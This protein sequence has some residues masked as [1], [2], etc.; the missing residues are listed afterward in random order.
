MKKFSGL[1]TVLLL[2]CV[3]ASVSSAE[4]ASPMYIGI[5]DIN[6]TLTIQSGQATCKG[7]V[8]LNS[9]SYGAD[10]TVTLQKQNG[11]SWVYVNSW[12]DSGSI[13]VSA[14]G[15][16]SVASGYIY[17]VRASATV[18]DS[19]GNVVERG[20]AYSAQKTY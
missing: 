8:T 7:I 12:S 20:S 19:F 16:V 4:M 9:T 1:F 15:S 6:A 5:G 18:K 14:N 2:L 13:L 11:N 17:R 10:I 3:V